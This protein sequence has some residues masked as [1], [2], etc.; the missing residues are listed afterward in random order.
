MVKVCLTQSM[1]GFVVR[2]QGSPRIT[3][4]R[5]Q[6]MTYIEEVFLG[7]PFNVHVQGA[8]VMDCTSFVCSLVNIVNSD[9]GSEFFC[10]ETVFSDKL[11]VDARDVSTR[12]YQCRGVNNFEGV[13][14]DD[15]LYRNT[16]R[17][18]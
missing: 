5:P 8:S 13:Q 11:P 9:G 16:H 12:V 18:V 17:F 10:G 15:Q 7:D 14:E 6:P 3:F 1:V 2:S 4:S